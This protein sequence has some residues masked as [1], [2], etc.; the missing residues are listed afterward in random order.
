MLEKSATHAGKF[1]T[2]EHTA[3]AAAA[4]FAAAKL[5]HHLLGLLELFDKPVHCCDIYAGAL[6]NAV[7]SLRGQESRNKF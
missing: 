2:A 7:L 6:C 1:T 3:H 5:L 4:F